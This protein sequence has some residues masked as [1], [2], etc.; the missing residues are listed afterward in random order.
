MTDLPPA[1]RATLDKE[2]AGGQVTEV[3][4]ETRNGKTIYS[5]DATVG[6]QLSFVVEKGEQVH[7]LEQAKALAA[8]PPSVVAGDEEEEQ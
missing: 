3:E 8:Q 7:S 6:G 5:A 2:T 4:K 1:V